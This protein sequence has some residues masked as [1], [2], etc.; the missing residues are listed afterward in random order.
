MVIG[1]SEETLA[2]NLVD[3]SSS[4]NAIEIKPAAQANVEGEKVKEEEKKPVYIEPKPLT[5][6]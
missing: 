5:L 4:S 3:Y 6:P 2:Q 1:L